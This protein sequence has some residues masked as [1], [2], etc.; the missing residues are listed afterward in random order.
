[1]LYMTRT[2]K[3]SASMQ[4]GLEPGLGDALA[5]SRS[6]RQSQQVE[7]LDGRSQVELLFLIKPGRGELPM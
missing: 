1:M 2:S 7:L 4:D 3:G 5:L 6:Y